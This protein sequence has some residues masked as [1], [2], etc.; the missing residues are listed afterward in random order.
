M[1]CVVALVAWVFVFVAYITGRAFFNTSWMFVEES[2]ELWLVLLG[3]FS[4]AYA[5]RSG[6]HIQIDFVTGLLPKRVRSILAVIT[7]LM[8]VV[9]VAYLVYKG[10]VWFWNG[11]ESGE[12][13]SGPLRTRL[14]PFY[15]L[16]PLGFGFLGLELLRELY[17]SVMRLMWGEEANF[18]K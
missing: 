16:I 5:L 10:T 11:F 7:G 17:Q 8:A 9:F 18:H 12:F 4:L 14:W 6:R 13:S 3:T 15:L 2:T 1:P